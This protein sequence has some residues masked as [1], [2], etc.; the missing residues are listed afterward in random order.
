MAL[1]NFVKEYTTIKDKQYPLSFFK[2]SK[3]LFKSSAKCGV[4]FNIILIKNFL[5][6]LRFNYIPNYW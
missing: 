1:K 6:F 4:E 2:L 3:R 5:F